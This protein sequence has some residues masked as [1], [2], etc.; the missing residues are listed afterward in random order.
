MKVCR[1]KSE[2]VACLREYLLN[3]KEEALIAVSGG[4]VIELFK[5]AIQGLNTQGWRV[6]MVDERLVPADHP[7]SNYGQL[8]AAC[9]NLSIAW[10]LD[11]VEY[12]RLL[13]E[14]NRNFD[15]VI[16]GMGLDGHTASLF[17]DHHSPETWGYALVEDAPKPPPNRITLTMP[18]INE[19]ADRVIVVMGE[20]KRPVAEAAIRGDKRYPVALVKNPTWIV[21]Y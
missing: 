20:A 21:F 13:Q 9:P 12:T 2:V 17:P 18:T 19:A 6:F 3:L 8:K 1:S 11:P 16:L 7:D 14:I 10:C 4:S 15:L 5:E